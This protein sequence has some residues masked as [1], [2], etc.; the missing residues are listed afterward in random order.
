MKYKVFASG[1]RPMNDTLTHVKSAADADIWGV[2]YP[3]Y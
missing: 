1:E 3:D 2:Y